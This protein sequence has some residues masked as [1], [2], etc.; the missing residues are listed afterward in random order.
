VQAA[1]GEVRDLRQAD[2]A[3]AAVA[4]LDGAGDE[5]L[6]L[7]TA[8]A[9]AGRRVVLGSAGDRGLVDLDQAGQRRALGRDHGPAELGAQQPGALVGAEAELPL[10]CVA[11]R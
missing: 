1:G 6:S 7:V 2:A 5:Q 10:E 3:G 8:A 11:I 4:D 9:A